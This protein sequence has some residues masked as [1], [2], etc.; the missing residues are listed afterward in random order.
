MKK[1][2]NSVKHRLNI[3][4]AKKQFD[5][6]VYPDKKTASHIFT[7]ILLLM[8]VLMSLITFVIDPLSIAIVRTI[9]SLQ[10]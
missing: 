5:L 9:T 8:I 7:W 10:F 1:F 4:D 6:L 3:K 2:Y